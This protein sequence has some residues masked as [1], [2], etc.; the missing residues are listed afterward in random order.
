MIKICEQCGEEYEIDKYK[1]KQRFCSRKCSTRYT[2]KTRIIP[3]IIKTCLFCGEDYE[4]KNNSRKY[5]GKSCSMAHFQS[6]KRNVKNDKNLAKAVPVI[7]SEPTIPVWN[8]I[9]R[10]NN[11]IF[12]EFEH[13][14]SVQGI[15][16]RITALD[17][18]KDKEPIDIRIMKIGE[19][20]MKNE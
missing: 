19:T 18:P 8:T 6:K 16:R 17:L 3:L 9:V 14:G 4:T 15:L 13:I 12:E 20:T 10:K 1:V 5:C 2:S 11:E 7:K